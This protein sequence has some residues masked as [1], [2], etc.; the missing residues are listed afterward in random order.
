MDAE[1]TRY[2]ELMEQGSKEFT[3]TKN[4][5]VRNGRVYVPNYSQ[6]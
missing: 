1:G 5:L 3:H 2:V 6:L 4:L